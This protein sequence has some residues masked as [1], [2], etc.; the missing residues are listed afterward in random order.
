MWNLLH[1]LRSREL[2]IIVTCRW[3]LTV[4][5]QQEIARKL[6]DWTKKNPRHH[7]YHTAPDSRELDV[8]SQL[9]I[10]SLKF[11][12]NC[13]I[14]ESI[15]CVDPSAKKRF[16]AIYDARLT[17][18]KRHELA[19][20]IANLALVTYDIP[21]NRDAGY[22]EKIGKLLSHATW[23]NGPFASNS[24]ELTPSEVASFLNQSQVGIML[25]SM[26]GGNYASLQYLLCGLPVVT[27]KNVGGRD[28]FFNPEHVIWADDNPEAIS[29][30]VEE[31]ISRQLDPQAIRQAALE[32]VNQHRNRLTTL[33]ANIC[34]PESAPNWENYYFHKLLH[35]YSPMQ[36]H[37]LKLKALISSFLKTDP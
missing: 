24:R 36:L 31:L 33:V 14:D 25:S 1:K 19:S 7:L 22:N 32:R 13:L 2:H 10:P 37:Q 28:E 12:N 23:L 29:D 17:P 9:N 34:A 11:A 4:E 21:L 8:L 16:R 35:K 30:A 20:K 26:E 27:T 5:D 3:T 15:F 6:H 18:F